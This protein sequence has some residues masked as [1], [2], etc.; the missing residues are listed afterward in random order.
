MFARNARRL[1]WL[2]SENSRPRGVDLL[3]LFAVLGGIFDILGAILL[4]VVASV[5]LSWLGKLIAP[6]VIP[7]IFSILSVIS[8]LLL[9]CGATSLFLAYGLWRGRGWAW[10]WA[11]TSALIGLA[12]STI[13]LGIG[14]GLV[15]VACNGLAVYYLTRMEVRFFFGKAPRARSFSSL[16]QRFCVHCGNRLDRKEVYCPT[17]GSKLEETGP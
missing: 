14:V 4:F 16:S 8:C 3:V 13:L 12:A 7:V 6:K 1:W 2:S 17:C 9:F 5:S 11:L 10:N 15:G